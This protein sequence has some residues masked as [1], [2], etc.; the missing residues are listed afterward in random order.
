[1]NDLVIMLFAK[2]F[3]ISAEEAQ[4]LFVSEYVIGHTSIHNGEVLSWRVYEAL[5]KRRS[6]VLS[7][8][9]NKHTAG[10]YDQAT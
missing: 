1:M 7:A 2:F 5:M 9:A 4:A 8:I 6:S 10:D 3:Q